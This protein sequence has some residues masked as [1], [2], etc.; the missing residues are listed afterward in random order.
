MWLDLAGSM[1]LGLPW[2]SLDGLV[3]A[4]DPVP[5]Q[6]QGHPKRQEPKGNHRRYRTVTTRT[7]SAQQPRISTNSVLDPCEV[8][9]GACTP[10]A[11]C[12]L[13]LP[14]VRR[15]ESAGGQPQLQLLH[16]V[17]NHQHC[18]PPDDFPTIPSETARMCAVLSFVFPVPEL[19]MMPE[20][21]VA[22]SWTALSG[23]RPSVC[24]TGVSPTYLFGAAQAHN[25]PGGGRRLVSS[26]CPEVGQPGGWHDVKIIP[27]I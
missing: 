22:F 9:E 3:V 20:V 8:L 11:H 23:C 14:R 27:S 10:A 6:S 1:R 4:A 18:L 21:L 19:Y 16:D 15:W 13:L 17:S 7:A 2:C 26:E 5:S 24:A 25:R 12:F